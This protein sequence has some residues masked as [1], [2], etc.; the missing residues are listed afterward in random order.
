MNTDTLMNF[1]LSDAGNAERLE[2]LIGEN[3]RYVSQIK[4]WLHFTGKRWEEDTP[5]VLAVAAIEGYRRLQDAIFAMPAPTDKAE[6][7]RR[8]MLTNWL[9]RSENTNKLQAA[10]KILQGVLKADYGIFDKDEYLLNLQNGTLNLR[11]LQLQPHDKRDY[12]TKIAGAAYTDFP[13]NSLWIR[14]VKEILPDAEIRNYMQRF[15]GYTLTASTEEEKF[16]VACGPGGCGKGTFFETIAAVLGEYKETLPIDIL[17]SSGVYGT[18][19]GPTPELAKL[20]GKRIVLSSESGK[21]RK[22]DEAKVKLLTGGDTITAR[23]LHAEPFE[24]KPAFKLV[25]QTNYMPSLADSLDNG[26]RRRMVVIPFNT[27][28][29]SRNNKLKAELL[30]PENLSECLHWLVDGL[31]VWNTVGLGPV[32]AAA[33]AAA[34]EY[35]RENDIFQQ[36]LDERTEASNGGGLLLTKAYEDFCSWLY[37][38]KKYSRIT[39]GA[40]IREHG[41]KTKRNG[42]GIVFENIALRLM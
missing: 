11:T 5:E 14:T 22:L 7:K 23:R 18:G 4:S 29:A 13:V 41:V 31:R 32:P 8:E 37:G 15:M 20:P 34:E 17:L 35:Y 21:G 33:A 3:W 12:I 16:I 28:I 40:A 10:I 19:N 25:F 1:P 42:K 27:T 2:I 30:K 26:I 39:F 6:R 38:G 36:W 9:E 24:F